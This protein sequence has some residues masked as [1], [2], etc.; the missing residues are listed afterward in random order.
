M[1]SE[2]DQAIQEL[3]LRLSGTLEADRATLF[4]LDRPNNEVWSKFAIGLEIS[5]IR[6]P[7]HRG[8]V[9]FVARTGRPLNLKDAYNDPR[10]NRNTDRQTGYRTKSM[11]TMPI[12]NEAG[13]VI[14]VFQALNKSSGLF[15][16]EDEQTMNSYCR[17]AALLIERL[18]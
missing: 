12:T 8:V 2:V 13:M 3:V 18:E 6:L 1:S 17:D 7:T 11:L 5:E 9:G 10:F 14:G 16:P 4:I 15:T